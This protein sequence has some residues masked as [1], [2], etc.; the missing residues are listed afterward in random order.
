MRPA[1][2]PG[3]RLVR[4]GR[5][6][7]GLVSPVMQPD[8]LAGGQSQAGS[9]RQHALERW[10]P[11]VWGMPSPP[12]LLGVPASPVRMRIME[13]EGESVDMEGS[14]HRGA[15]WGRSAGQGRGLQCRAAASSPR[16]ASDSPSEPP[17]LQASPPAFHTF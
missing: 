8:P 14:A 13:K 7:R 10:V 16:G 11:L 15:S 17:E 4:G 6:L 12:S 5:G 9:S 3:Y 1:T 2:S